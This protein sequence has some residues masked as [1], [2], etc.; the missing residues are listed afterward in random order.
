MRAAI[1]FVAYDNRAGIT[2]QGS[3]VIC[4]TNS[5]HC[6]KYSQSLVMRGVPY[7]ADY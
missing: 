6:K 3:G 5:R 1:I 4:S 7:T 2:A